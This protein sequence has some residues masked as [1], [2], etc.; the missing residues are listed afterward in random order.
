MTEKGKH[1]RSWAAHSSRSDLL[2]RFYKADTIR[3][4][5]E[6]PASPPSNTVSGTKNGETRRLTLANHSWLSA[7]RPNFRHSAGRS[8]PPKKVDVNGRPSDPHRR[9]R[10]V[11]QFCRFHTRCRAAGFTKSRCRFASPPA[12][13]VQLDMGRSNKSASLHQLN[14]APPRSQSKERRKLRSCR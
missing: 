2:K 13:G 1:A 7:V 11:G 6:C 4:A 5:G 9:R 10:R 14:C 8:S 3:P 12:I